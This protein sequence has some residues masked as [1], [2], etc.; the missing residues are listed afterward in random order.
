MEK[1]S[2]NIKFTTLTPDMSFGSLQQLYNEPKRKLYYELKVTR[3]ALVLFVT[4]ISA[5]AYN[6]KFDA[7]RNKKAHIEVAEGSHFSF[8]KIFIGDE[9][10]QIQVRVASA[11]WQRQETFRVLFESFNENFENG[12]QDISHFLPLFRSMAGQLSQLTIKEAFVDVSYKK[13][14]IDFNLNL[15]KGVFLSVAKRTDE[16]SEDVMFTIARNHQTLVIDEM[17]LKELIQRVSEIM[18]ELKAL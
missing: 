12:K 14:L 4:P 18:L 10:I 15:E 13:E 7:E 17:P 16:M 8:Q 5:N 1:K 9:T 11:W 3:L 6:A 2:D